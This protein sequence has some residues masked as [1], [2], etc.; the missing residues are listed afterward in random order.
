MNSCFCFIDTSNEIS[1]SEP[2]IT[3]VADSS[4][5]GPITFRCS[6]AGL[7]QLYLPVGWYNYTYSDNQLMNCIQTV[8]VLGE[9]T[10]LLVTRVLILT[11]PRFP[12][13]SAASSSRVFTKLPVG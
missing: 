9:D 5:T 4:K 11:I 1:C 2:A 7:Y 6:K 3:S 12:D 8:N 10:L 13:T